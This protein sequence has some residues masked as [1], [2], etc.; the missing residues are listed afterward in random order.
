MKSSLSSPRPLPAKGIRGSRRGPRP[1]KPPVTGPGTRGGLRKSAGFFGVLLE[2]AE[3][4][5]P[6]FPAPSPGIGTPG[7]RVRA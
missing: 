3:L 7:P 4:M 5:G 1:V 6:D 2:F